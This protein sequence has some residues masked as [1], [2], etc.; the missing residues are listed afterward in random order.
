L[1]T[2]IQAILEIREPTYS[3]SV[4]NVFIK[5]MN[6]FKDSA[7]S[8][9]ALF[10]EQRLNFLFS[11]PCLMFQWLLTLSYNGDI[12]KIDLPGFMY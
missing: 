7:L 6:V 2:F 5:W 8:F 3:L 9:S 4:D 12:L 10:I 11:K 1:Y